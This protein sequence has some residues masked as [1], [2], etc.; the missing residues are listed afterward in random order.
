M[1]IN[2][3]II[4]YNYIKSYIFIKHY[5]STLKHSLSTSSLSGIFQIAR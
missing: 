1:I 3:L 4:Y 2:S 5:E